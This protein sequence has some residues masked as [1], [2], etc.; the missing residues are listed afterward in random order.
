L[1]FF[2]LN[3]A[4]IPGLIAILMFSCTGGKFRIGHY[5][6]GKGQAV[7]CGD[8]LSTAIGLEILQNGGNAVD[9]ATAVILSLSITDSKDFCFGGEAAVLIYNPVNKKVDAIS[10]IGRAPQDS[11]AIQWYLKHGIPTDDIRS[12]PVPAVLGLLVTL[13]ENYGTLTFSEISR[14]SLH[15]LEKNREPWHAAFSATLKKLVEVENNFPDDRLAG[16]K[17]VNHRFYHEDI[18][19]SLVA[20]YQRSHGFLSKADLENH[21]TL[22]ENPVSVSCHGYTIFKCGPWTQ[23]PVLCEA[24]NILDHAKLNTSQLSNP[25]LIHNAVESMKLAMADRDEYFGDPDFVRVPLDSLLSAKYAEIRAGLIPSKTSSEN[26]IAGDPIHMKAIK[27]VKSFENWQPGT[28]TCCVIDKN[29]MMV[30]ATPS[31]WGS[32]AGPGGFTGIWH[33]TR[34]RSFNISPGHPDCIAPGKRPRVTLT[35]TLILKNNKPLATIAVAGGDVQDQVTFN[36]IIY[37]IIVNRSPMEAMQLPRFVTNFHQDSFNPSGDR[38]STLP[39]E[40]LLTVSNEMSDKD[41]NALQQWGHHVKRQ[42]I[43]GE[44]VMIYFN[45]QTSEI[46]VVTDAK[47]NHYGGMIGD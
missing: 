22:I 47:T 12:A 20:W 1:R 34:L 25:E 19:D 13:L 14:P 2:Y 36:I 29:G 9:A 26:A 11:A 43:I 21:K 31:G 10:G 45:Q 24:L 6:S 32:T 44:P 16:L 39:P 30:S 15:L 8:S 28:T 17:A 7:A 33:S 4:F 41:F 27:D 46:K 23:G 35:P 18:A 5:E 37:M 38:K 42:D 40:I 3:S